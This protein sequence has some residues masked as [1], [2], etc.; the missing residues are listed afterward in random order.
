[1]H[2]DVKQVFQILIVDDNENNL[3]T[4]DTLI[5]EH[6]DAKIIQADSGMSALGILLKTPV[7]LI[8]LDV[9]MPEMDGFETAQ[10]IRSRKKTCH[11]PIVFLTA[12]YKSEQF[13]QKG[14]EVGGAD[15][16][17]KPIDTNQ[18]I[19]R[20]KSYLRF[21]E[22]ERQ[23]KLLLEKTVVERTRELE[24]ARNSLEQ[25]VL[26]RTA[27]LFEAKNIAE[28]L[29][30]EAE[31]ANRSKSQFLANMSHELRT[32]LNAIIGYS[33]LLQEEAEELD[34]E[35]DYFTPD[36]KKIHSAGEHLLGLI[37]DILDLSKIEAGK[38]ELELESFDVEPIFQATVN[39]VRPLAEKN[40]NQV[41]F[42]AI[43]D[44]SDV[45]MDST[46]LRQ[47]VLNLLSNALKF[48]EHASVILQVTRYFDV[49]GEWLT[50]CV[51]DEGIGMTEQQLDKLF[52]PFTQ[53]DAS[54]TRR[55]GGTG[56][57]LTISKEFVEMMGGEIQVNSEFGYGSTFSVR[58]P[59]Y[60]VIQPKLDDKI[61]KPVTSTKKEGIVLVIDDDDT[62]LHL[63]QDYL[64][65]LG[66]AVALA[67]NGEEGLFLANKLR[68]DAI[69]LDIYMPEPH[70]GWWVLDQ[71]KQNSLLADIPVITT[72]GSD[73][74]EAKS[75][76]LGAIDYL[77]K[78]IQ[79][80][81]LGNILAKHHIVGSQQSQLV[82]IV[83]D[84]EICRETTAE[85]LYKAGWRVFKAENGQVALEHLAKK[86]PDLILL[87]LNMPVMDG[88]QFLEVLQKNTYWSKIPVV[89]LTSQEL[90]EQEK[91]FLQ[92]NTQ[93]VFDKSEQNV[94]SLL[95]GLHGLLD[96]MLPN[97]PR[98]QT[99]TKERRL[100]SIVK[101]H[102]KRSD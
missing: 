97:K 13:K 41:Y 22:Q 66:Y 14:F 34:P 24:E 85:M 89:V 49:E 37:N 2:F 93:A 26:E 90:T 4:L 45:F 3:F 47:I 32:P 92:I 38:M 33:E 77:A 63:F 70:D 71:L 43:G 8:I 79:A 100:E 69:I 102:V 54:T 53:A 48:T 42:E 23:H 88:F 10:L 96:E 6:L 83:E 55:Y 68:P 50:F 65:Q 64:T 46:K 9:Q 20:I 15:Y 60:T 98:I 101:Q 44:L 61:H 82:M 74:S 94:Q 30:S 17:T 67:K 62:I 57:G 29:Q 99:T 1:M 5:K 19:N 35:Q 25:R 95:Q 36:L 80:E 84:N 11:I 87:D 7:D 12:A 51:I 73:H 56:L 18:L 16:L 76:S 28:K 21:I 78:P 58:I 52:H 75:L 91:D 59:C 81:H 27:E 72:S 40:Q 86:Q 39:T 31:Q